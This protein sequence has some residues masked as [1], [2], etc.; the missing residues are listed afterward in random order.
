LPTRGVA[1]DYDG[2]RLRR[3]G[4]NLRAI[5]RAK[6]DGRWDQAYD[7]PGTSKVPADFQA[8]LDE[9]AKAKAFFATL[10]S[11]NRFAILF[12]LQTAKKKET[13]S[14]RIE[15]FIRMLEKNEKLHP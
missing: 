10:N 3:Y 12:R 2:S 8:A 9:N 6:Q 14:K 5:E 13:R 15:Q 1:L 11:A 7:S 4:S